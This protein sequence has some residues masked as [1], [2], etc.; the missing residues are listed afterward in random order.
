MMPTVLLLTG[1]CGVGKTTTARAWAARR[2]GA[3]VGGDEVRGWMRDLPVRRANDYQQALV[4]RVCATAAEEFL[5]LGLD[6][7]LDFVWKPPTLRYLRDRLAPRADVRM[8]YLDCARA[9]N[10]RRDAERPANVVMGPRCDE[11][12]AE[13]DAL[14]D[15]PAEMRRIDT[16]AMPLD[17]VLAELDRR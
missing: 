9:E 1:T 4:A 7:A 12:R 3:S 16:T 8:V 10:R 6:V 5:T 17:A 15:W 2:G 11:L 13:L 14:A